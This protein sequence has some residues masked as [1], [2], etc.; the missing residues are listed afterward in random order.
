M[1]AGKAQS[2][3][4]FGDD[5]QCLGAFDDLKSVIHKPP[6][7]GV[8]GRHGGGINHQRL[9]WIAAIVG[10]KRWVIVV[11]DVY[12][13]GFQ[14][15]CEVTRGAVIASHAASTCQEIALQCGHPNAARA[16]KI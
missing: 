16:N 5:A 2:F 8:V 6:Q 4:M 15:V 12:A 3:A 11:V 14:L 13:L 9:L 1:G 7:H 10:D